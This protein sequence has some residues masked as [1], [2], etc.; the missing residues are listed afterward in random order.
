MRLAPNSGMTPTLPFPSRILPRRR[1]PATGRAALGALLLLAG[2]SG[3]MRPLTRRLDSLAEQVRLTNEQLAQTNRSLLETRALLDSADRRLAA[4]QML[5]ASTDSG[6]TSTDARL[7]LTNDQL[8]LTNKQLGETNEQLTNLRA[9]I[10]TMLG[11]IPDVN[12][13]R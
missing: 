10:R 9:L 4:M 3:C 2:A 12:P 13:G 7:A 8:G 5:L 11:R 1:W 6:V